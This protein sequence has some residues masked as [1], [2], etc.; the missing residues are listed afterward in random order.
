MERARQGL[1]LIGY[2]EVGREV[3]TAVATGQLPD[4]RLGAVLTR[5]RLKDPLPEGA[6]RCCQT[7]ANSSQYGNNLLVLCSTELLPFDKSSFALNL[8]CIS[9]I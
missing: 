2:G 9:R 3:A 8:K 1:G 6:L 4:Y 7:N 5:N